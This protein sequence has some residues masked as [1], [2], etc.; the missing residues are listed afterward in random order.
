MTYGRLATIVGVKSPRL[1][2]NVLHKNKDSEKIPCH[3]VVNSKGMVAK[4]FAFGG[5][6]EHI[7]RLSKEGIEVNNN[8][9]DLN[10]YLW[11][12]KSHTKSL[13]R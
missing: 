2:G 11:E 13:T 6:R 4:N 8:R 7:K 10:K 12:N 5:A 9:V 1:V 3:R